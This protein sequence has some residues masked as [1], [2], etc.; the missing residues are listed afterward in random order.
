VRAVRAANPRPHPRSG[1]VPD[2]AAALLGQ[3]AAMGTPDEVRAQLDAWDDVAD[4]V[5]IGLPPGVPWPVI[6]TTLR[7]AAPQPARSPALSRRRPVA[8]GGHHRS[9]RSPTRRAP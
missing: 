2:E 9:G 8:G 7:A 1:Q 4:V 3:L 6:E 5:M